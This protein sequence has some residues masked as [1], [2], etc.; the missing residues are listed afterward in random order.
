MTYLPDLAQ[1]FSV[2]LNYLYVSIE[3]YVQDMSKEG[4]NVTCQNS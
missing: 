1:E 2:G 4:V 3:P